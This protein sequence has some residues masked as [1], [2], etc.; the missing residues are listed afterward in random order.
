MRCRPM[1]RFV[2][3]T[4]DQKGDVSALR[5]CEDGGDLPRIKGP[6][7]LAGMACSCQNRWT[8]ISEGWIQVIALLYLPQPSLGAI[9]G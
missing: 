2:P 1:P 9:N 7:S 5:Y 4:G 8:P 6:W 3:E